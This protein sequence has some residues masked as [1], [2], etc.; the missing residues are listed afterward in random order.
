[1]APVIA[2][3][4][5]ALGCNLDA[6]EGGDCTRLPEGRNRADCWYASLRT[7]RDDDAGFD[8]T[9][10]RVPAPERDALLLRLAADAPEVRERVCARVSDPAARTSCGTGTVLP[11]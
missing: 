3:L 6:I 4:A 11:R 9:L 8:A 2:L 7:V 10:T 5:A 1:M